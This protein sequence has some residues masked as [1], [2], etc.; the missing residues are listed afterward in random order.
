MSF[1][2]GKPAAFNSFRIL[3]INISALSIRPCSRY[4]LTEIAVSLS[5]LSWSRV[6][7]LGISIYAICFIIG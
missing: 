6:G 2:K 4:Q 3:S 5:T 7:A 1:L